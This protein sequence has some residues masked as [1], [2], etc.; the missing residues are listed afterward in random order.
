MKKYFVASFFTKLSYDFCRNPTYFLQRFIHAF[1]SFHLLLF[2]KKKP[3]NSGCSSQLV[4]ISTNLIDVEV[5]DQ[6]NL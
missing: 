5:N 4:H 1:G 2:K 6:I 3:K